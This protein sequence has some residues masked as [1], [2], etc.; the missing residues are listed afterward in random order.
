MASELLAAG[1]LEAPGGSVVRLTER[2]WALQEETGGYGAAIA[3]RVYAG[4]TP[5]G[6]ATAGRVLSVATAR[7]NAEL[8][9]E[10]G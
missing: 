1:L 9:G 2:G 4:F 7:A 3:A 10:Q 8:A 5:E 6:L